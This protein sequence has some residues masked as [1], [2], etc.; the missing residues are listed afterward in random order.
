MHDLLSGFG[1]RDPALGRSVLRFRGGLNQRPSGSRSLSRRGAAGH[2]ALDKTGTRASQNRG[3]RLPAHLLRSIGPART[4]N[5]PACAGS[6]RP[7]R[8]TERPRGR[9]LRANRKGNHHGKAP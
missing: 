9:T 4:L 3:F 1:I 5:R 7:H 2:A 6:F 8:R